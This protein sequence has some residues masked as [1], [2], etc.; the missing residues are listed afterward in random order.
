MCRSH[1]TVLLSLVRSTHIRR[2]PFGL[3]TTM[4]PAHQSV[5][6]STLAMTPIASILL[7]SCFT[8]GIRGNAAL[9]GLR[10]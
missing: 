1:L 7:I 10:V 6:C 8:L 2:L 3:G 5:G 9:L 4:I